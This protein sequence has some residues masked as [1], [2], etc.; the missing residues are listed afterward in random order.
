MSTQS[1]GPEPAA[2]PEVELE[3]ADAVEAPGLVGGAVGAGLGAAVFAGDPRV[4][5][6]PARVL[7]L[8]ARAGNA[9]VARPLAARASGPV[10]ARAPDMAGQMDEAASTE[11]ARVAAQPP[12]RV[13][14]MSTVNDVEQARTQL[15]KINEA[16]PHLFDAKAVYEF[17]KS[18]T[19]SYSSKGGVGTRR[20]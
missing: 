1:P 17:E 4:G 18:D 16:I 7:A 19:S 20:S 10:A 11:A 13:G 6:D 12:P 3:V 15:R 9:G 5:L 2:A 8:S 14:E